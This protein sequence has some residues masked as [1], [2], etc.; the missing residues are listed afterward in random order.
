MRLLFIEDDQRL[1][2]AL[3]AGLQEEG[4]VV[5]LYHDGDEGLAALIATAYDGCILDV[6]L[7]TRDGFSVLIAARRAAVTTP[8]LILTARDTVAD[9][10]HGLNH[11]ADDYLIKPFAFAELLARLR[12]LL[13]RGGPQH[14]RDGRLRLGSLELDP[15]GHEVRI[16]GRS[17]DLTKTQF[18]L[19]ECLLRHRG[20]VVTRA[21]LLSSVW[22]YSFDPETNLIDVHIAEL[23]RRLEPTGLAGLIRTIRGVGYRADELDA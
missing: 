1:A 8:I 12:A 16:A 9:R 18:A 6:N 3:T 7:P 10:V 17:L 14:G 23:R 5:D 22:G 21:M 2:R 13:R 15:V 19:L 4:F 20:Q 11:G